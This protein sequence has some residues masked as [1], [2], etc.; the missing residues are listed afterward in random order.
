[1]PEG[2]SGGWQ[3]GEFTPNSPS[4]RVTWVTRSDFGTVEDVEE[5]S[6]DLGRISYPTAG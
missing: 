5:R 1:L 4:A 3:C 6:R 2:G